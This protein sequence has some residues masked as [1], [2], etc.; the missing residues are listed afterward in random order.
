MAGLSDLARDEDSYTYYRGVT[1]EPAKSPQFQATAK[2]VHHV[3]ENPSA[4][5]PIWGNK[6]HINSGHVG[7]DQRRDETNRNSKGVTGKRR[8]TR[9]GLG[10]GKDHHSTGKRHETRSLMRVPQGLEVH[11]SILT[12]HEAPSC[13]KISGS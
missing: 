4:S 2:H 10:V 3:P 6:T 8:E 9:Q 1:I 13:W 5:Q 11:A 12:R 7:E